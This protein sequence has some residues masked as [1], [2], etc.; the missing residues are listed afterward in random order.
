MLLASFSSAFEDIIMSIG[1][2]F[3]A[4]LYIGFLVFSLLLLVMWTIMPFYVREIAL[5]LRGK[6]AWMKDDQSLQM[7]QNQAL[8][9]KLNRINHQLAQLN[10]SLGSAQIERVQE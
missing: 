9:D 5:K 7:A 6:P 4:V 8:H 2:F 1:P 10:E 3:S